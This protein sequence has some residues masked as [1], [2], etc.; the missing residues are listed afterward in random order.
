[1]GN[2]ETIAC[3]V[4]SIRLVGTKEDNSGELRLSTIH[5]HLHGCEKEKQRLHYT[6]CLLINLSM[7]KAPPITVWAG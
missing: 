5:L 6:G 2:A 7:S 1:M 4:C 3:S